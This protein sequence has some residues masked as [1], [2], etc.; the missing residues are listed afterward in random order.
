M[1]KRH[2]T[3]L[4]LDW[5]HFIGQRTWTDD[6]LRVA[7]VEAGS[8][9]QIAKNL[10]LYPGANNT[11]PIRDRIKVLGL[12]YKTHALPRKSNAENVATWRRRLKA[13]LVEEAGGRCFDCGVEGPPYIFDFDHREPGE[14]AFAVSQTGATVSLKRVREEIE[15]CDLVCANCHRHR[16]HRQRCSGCVHCT[17]A[18]VV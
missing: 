10:G 16:T 5:S 14:K 11:G 1:L 12:E 2:A 8:L 15:K 13:L 7:V 3:R 18:P 17:Q 9:K 6:E 4:G